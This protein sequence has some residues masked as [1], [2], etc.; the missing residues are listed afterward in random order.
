MMR[1]SKF[2]KVLAES[3][4]SIGEKQVNQQIED[5]LGAAN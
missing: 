1:K 2:A 5:H 3:L 4:L